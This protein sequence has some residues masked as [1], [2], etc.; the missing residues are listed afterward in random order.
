MTRDEIER[1]LEALEHEQRPAALR[2]DDSEPLPRRVAVLSSAFNPPT[3]AHLGLLEIATEVPGVEGM[4]AL[5][6]TRNV[7]K[8]VFGASLTDR[9][10]MLLAVRQAQP[11]FAVLATNMARFVDQAEALQ[12]TFA[13]TDFDFVVGYDT[14]VRL[15]ERKYYTAMEAELE[16]FFAHNRLIAANRGEASMAA[17]EAFLERPEVAPHRDE[18]TVLEL[19]EE[20]AL[21]S[22]TA[23]REAAALGADHGGTVPDAVADYIDRHRLY[24][25]AGKLSR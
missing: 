4:G 14:L 7:A 6:T 11:A 24:R 19:D 17:V 12:N 13:G 18:I 16:R 8:D 21:L 23:A 2:F 1:R 9:I 3:R 10:G 25:E 15:F 22:S 20:R 5:L